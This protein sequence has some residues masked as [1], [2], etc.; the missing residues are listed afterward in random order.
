M[1]NVRQ[2]EE[3]RIAVSIGEAGRLLGVSS[4]TI[5]RRIEASEIRAKKIGRRTV[6][7]VDELRRFIEAR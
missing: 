6:V 5:I 1:E 4:R 3:G 7:S 2:T